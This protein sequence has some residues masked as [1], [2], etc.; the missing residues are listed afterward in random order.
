MTPT[1]DK[2]HNK[3]KLN[4]LHFDRDDLKEVAYSYIKE[5][6]PYEKEIGDF[7]MEWT[8]DRDVVE[9][10]TSG[11][12]GQPK[13]IKL[14]KQAMVASALATGNYFNLEP[15]D[16]CLHC[17]PAHFIA[18]KMMLIRAMILGLELT[19]VEPLSRPN[20]DSNQVFVFASMVPIQLEKTI[21][22]IDNIQLI[23]V[24][25]APVSKSLVSKI[26]QV[27]PAVFETYGMTETITHIAAKRLNGTTKS[28]YFTTLPEVMVSQDER[29]CLIVKAPY[30]SNEPITTNDVVELISETEF[31]WL[32]RADHII[33]VGGIKIHPEL[34][35]AK[36]HSKLDRRFFVTSETDAKLGEHLV[37]V[38]EGDKF[39]V[40]STTFNQLDKFE[41][42]KNIYFTPKFIET[43][44]G[45]I[46]VLE[47]LKKA[48]ISK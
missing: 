14:K 32:G 28:D 30:L 6:E 13:I 10:R 1:Y 19:T 22:F 35:E 34:I 45:K 5:G 36:L 21:N 11:S 40:P 26:N 20:F 4:G 15:G 27:R 39:E 24:G 42:P 7:L 18:G 43:T 2:I 29:N 16:T 44:P 31:K 3:F 33:N 8:N 12:T 38:I 9:V 25:G 23:L 41:I 46:Q 17:L 37:M 47:T 48:K